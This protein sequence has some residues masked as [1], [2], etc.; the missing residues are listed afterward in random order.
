M[1][2]SPGEIQKLAADSVFGRRLIMNSFRG[3]IAEA[4]IASALE[5]AWRWCAADWASWDF[6]HQDGTR[7]EVKQSAARQS[8]TSQASGRSAP[9]FDIQARTGHWADG[10]TWQ[11]NETGERLAHL[12]VFAFHPILG[13]AAGRTKD[14]GQLRDAWHLRQPGAELGPAGDRPSSFL[15]ALIFGRL[16]NR[17]AFCLL[18]IGLREHCFQFKQCRHRQNQK[19]V[20]VSCRLK[21]DRRIAAR[22]RAH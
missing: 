19:H 16:L 18:L 22:I 17:L 4:I 20:G 13:D 8:W 5:P 10:V 3:V 7:L 9:K 1:P 21:L 12:Y 15:G 11:A 14:E 2:P 6:E